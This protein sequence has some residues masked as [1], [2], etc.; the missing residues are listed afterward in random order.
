MWRI[1]PYFFLLA[2]FTPAAAQFAPFFEGNRVGLR[3]AQGQ[4]VV[5]PV[6][7]ALG[8]SDGSSAVVA[9]IIGFRMQNRWGLLHLD[10]RKITEPVYVELQPAGGDYF[11]AARQINPF[12]IKFGLLTAEGKTA[13]PFYYDGLRVFGLRAI[14][15]NKNGSR[16]EYGVIT[17]NDQRIIPI[18]YRS[19]TPLGTL[20][21]AVE[22]FNRKVALF[23][24][25][26]EALSDFTIDSISAFRHDYAIVYQQLHQGLINRQG[27]W[28]APPRYR[29]IRYD[30]YWRGWTFPNWKILTSAHETLD[31]LHADAL[32]VLPPYIRIEQANRYGLLNQNWTTQLPA[33]YEVLERCGQL[34]MARWQGKFGLI[35]SDGTE[36]LP[37][38][39][40]SLIVQGQLVRAVERPWG[41]PLWS[42]YDT[43]GI[44]K[45]KRYYEHIL[46]FRSNRFVVVANG[47]AGVV[48]RFGNEQVACVYDSILQV[49]DEMLAVRFKGLYGLISPDDRWLLMPQPQPV[50]IVAQD[51]YLVREPTATWLKRLG[52]KVIYFTMNPV[53]VENGHLREQLPGQPDRHIGLD[54]REQKSVSPKVTPTPLL[55][56]EQQPVPEWFAEHEGMRGFQRDGRYGF[57]DARGKL[58]VANRYEGIGYFSEGLAAVKILGRWGYVNTKDQVVINP[59]FDTVAPFVADRSIVARDGRWGVI[60]RKGEL[61]IPLRYSA[62]QAMPSGDYRIELDDLTGIANQEGMVLIEPRFDLLHVLPTS[63]VLVRQAGKYGV[64][65]RDGLSRIPMLYDLLIYQEASQTFLARLP[66]RE[67]KLFP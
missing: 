5:P 62:V 13:V 29:E 20:R 59:N 41:D 60:N 54:G 6:Y 30:Q 37:F 3:N 2:S 17:L 26:G 19:V 35:R 56:M 50:E 38:R 58:R 53:R 25:R 46:P 55:T 9:G 31:T 27:E 66:A 4:V 57:V 14:V 47:Y 45:T 65:T 48:D 12:T 16:Y 1:L 23:S 18:K 39:F 43:F 63:D 52:G 64:L 32:T 49:G 15:F 42:V 51:Y 22:D 8:W 7:D 36:V 10:N 11:L 21:F 40:D 67:E 34:W 33:R 24:D 28:A 61:V 44:R